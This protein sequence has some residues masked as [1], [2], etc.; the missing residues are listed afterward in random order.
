MSAAKSGLWVKAA[1][2]GPSSN[3]NMPAPVM[4]VVPTE[5]EETASRSPD[6]S[7]VQHYIETGMV[8]EWKRQQKRGEA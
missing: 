7:A 3:A 8:P 2:M 4:R 5:V 6:L 1:Q